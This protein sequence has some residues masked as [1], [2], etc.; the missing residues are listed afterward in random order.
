M[1]RNGDEA[2]RRL[3]E[4]ALEL[5]SE[6][7]FD[8]TTTA[9]IAARAG[10]TER[11]YFRHFADKR[12]VLFGGES[13]LRDTMTGAIAA[14]PPQTSPLDLVMGSY[15]AAVPLFV[16]GRRVALRRAELIDATPALQERAHAKTAALADAIVESLTARGIPEPTARLAAQ[17]GAA[18]FQRA[19]A[20]WYADP[21]LDLTALVRAAVDEVRRL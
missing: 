14:A 17:V 21:S 13:E 15:L 7:G 18:A 2:R 8:A 11:T 19:G 10:V 3:R 12:E 4:A 16:A 9:Q 5:Y 6:Q 20:Q 1:P